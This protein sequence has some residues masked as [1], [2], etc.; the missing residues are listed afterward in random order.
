MVTDTTF[1]LPSP[2]GIVCLLL[3]TLKKGQQGGACNLLRML[4]LFTDWLGPYTFNLP[5][6][7]SLATVTVETGKT[8]L[9]DW[10]VLGLPAA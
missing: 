9:A 3:A 10:L 5:P 4:T 2:D 6:R 7:A 8:P 1:P